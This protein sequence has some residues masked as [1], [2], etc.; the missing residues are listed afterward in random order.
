[1]NGEL[2][3]GHW[4]SSGTLAKNRGNA[5][6]AFDEKIEVMPG[7][8]YCLT[9]PHILMG[10]GKAYVGFFNSASNYIENITGDFSNRVSIPFTVPDYAHYI[11]ISLYRSGQVFTPAEIADA[12]VNLSG[13]RD[14]EYEPYNHHSYPLDSSLTLR[15]IPKLDLDNNLYF[16]GDEYTTDGKV[17]RR[18]GIVDLGTLSWSYNIG[19]L[20]AFTSNS[21]TSTIASRNII[22][23][24]Y[25]TKSGG[26]NNE[27]VQA[28]DKWISVNRGG[29]TS[30]SLQAGTIIVRDSAYNDATAFKTAMS[31]VYLIYELIAMTEETAESYTGTQIVDDLGTEE[32][33]TTGIVPVGHETRYPANLRDK[34]QHLPDPAS[35]DGY[36]MI[37]QTS[38]EMS[39]AS[40]PIPL[41]PTENG[42][43]ILKVTVANGTPTYTW[44]V[45]E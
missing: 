4:W 14:G 39:L 43:Y 17:R 37:H 21:L 41:V 38:G 45:A 27:E 22:C 34:L 10:T 32:F 13:S 20:G 3:L 40:H 5:Y 6:A 35:S 31:G 29:S 26:T 30:G 8:R 19:S 42:T 2:M 24:A 18:Y 36:Y 28:G 23:N 16:D 25:L 33:V 7:K 12:C 15:G 11:T 44:E 9:V 1:M